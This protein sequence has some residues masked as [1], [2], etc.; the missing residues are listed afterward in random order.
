M[1]RVLTW[2]C[3]SSGA[4]GRGLAGETN[5]M[6]PGYVQGIRE[7]PTQ[8]AAGWGHTALVTEN[9]GQLVVFG[10][11]VDIRNTIQFG[12][13]AQSYPKLAFVWTQ[14]LGARNSIDFVCP[15][16]LPTPR[17]VVKIAASA[18]LTLGLYDDGTCFGMGMDRFGQ[19]GTNDSQSRGAGVYEPTPVF[20]RTA[21]DGTALDGTALGGTLEND[22]ESP[23]PNEEKIV[24]IACGHQ[25]G[26][27]LSENGRVFAWGK[28]DRGQI[29][30]GD[31]SLKSNM[32]RSPILVQGLEDIQAIA[33]GFA[34]N[35]ALSKK[36]TMYLWGTIQSSDKNSLIAE[37]KV[38]E[39]FP[40]MTEIACGQ[41]HNLCRDQDGSVYQWG[42]RPDQLGGGMVN[43]P[44]RVRGLDDVASG[45]TLVGAMDKSSLVSEDGVA[46]EWD[47]QSMY[48]KPMQQLLGKRVVQVAFGW[49]HTVA[50]VEET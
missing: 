15:T 22:L 20:T 16:L 24:D 37:P 13:L 48:A 44:I 49:K 10:R 46:Y 9:T 27:A 12:R 30:C 34:H 1:K 23:T 36:G 17:R 3:N 40:P 47:W 19:T 11:A 6:V 8:I 26:L 33:C 43:K 28:A 5:Q 25:H 4:L 45:S 29:G 41:F 2:G 35:V 14:Y 42:L 18:C 7:E 38:C 50:L 32:V 39:A 31:R 21:L